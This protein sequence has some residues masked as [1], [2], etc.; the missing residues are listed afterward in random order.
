MTDDEEALYSGEEGDATPRALRGT[1]SGAAGPSTWQEVRPLALLQAHLVLAPVAW[2]LRPPTPKTAARTHAHT[3]AHT[4]HT[5]HN[6]H[7]CP[8][9]PGGPR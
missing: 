2:P 4:Q 3:R 9:A 5:T 1:R 6:T 8:P 7:T